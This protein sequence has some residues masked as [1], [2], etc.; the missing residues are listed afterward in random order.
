MWKENGRTVCGRMIQ[1][2]WEMIWPIAF[3]ELLTESC[4]MVFPGVGS[5]AVQTISAAVTVGVLGILYGGKTFSFMR[6]R[7]KISV[8]TLRA[9]IFWTFLLLCTAGISSSLLFNNLITLSRIKNR[10]TGYRKVAAVLYSPPL[11]FQMLAMGVVLPGAEEVIFRGF[12]YKAFRKRCGFLVSAVISSLLFGVYHGSLVQGTYA[13]LV[14]LVLAYGRER[15]GTLLVP[16]VIHGSANLTSILVG[17]WLKIEE[18]MPYFSF[19]LVTV[20]SGVCLL[21]V[22]HV[23]KGYQQDAG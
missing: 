11:W 16:W 12:V 2:I 6:N 5:L 1:W 17:K 21:S 22:I 4:R 7:E 13:F 10:F 9:G 3:Y 19:L 14:A 18:G 23:M 15:Y 20:L 8:K